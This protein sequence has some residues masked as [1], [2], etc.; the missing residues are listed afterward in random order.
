MRR[1]ASTF[2]ALALSCAQAPFTT[3]DIKEPARADVVVQ[4]GN[5]SADP[6]VARVKEGGS[7]AWANQSDFLAVLSFPG[8]DANEFNCKDLRPDFAKEGNTLQS[9]PFRSAPYPVVLPCSL[10]KG[11][12]P[13]VINL[14]NSIEDLGNPTFTLSAEITVE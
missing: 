11:R 4:I 6:A 12:Y 1:F 13:Y 5:S 3:P 7:V 8:R 14:I 10:K 9:L 2:F